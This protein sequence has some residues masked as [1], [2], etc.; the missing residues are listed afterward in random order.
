MPDKLKND[1]TLIK[2]EYNSKLNCL[3]IDISSHIKH[4]VENIKNLSNRLF[5]DICGSNNK[6]IVNNVNIVTSTYQI[7]DTE[8][9]ETINN[10][11]EMQK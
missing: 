1:E 4:E 7:G 11:T 8:L 10:F 9:K 3:N 5:N 2:I 6:D